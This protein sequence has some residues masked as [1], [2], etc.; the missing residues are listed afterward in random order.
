MTQLEHKLQ[1]ELNLSRV[2]EGVAAGDGSEPSGI[3]GSGAYSTCK[4]GDRVVWRSK[5]RRIR[6]V[7]RLGAELQFH[8][9]AYREISEDR[10]VD[11]LFRWREQ[12]VA[13]F[14][15]RKPKRL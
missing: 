14:V 5:I 13:P 2:V 15:A 6:Q 7:K 12:R 10:E 3:R 9:L 4:C 1:R 11:S 8:R